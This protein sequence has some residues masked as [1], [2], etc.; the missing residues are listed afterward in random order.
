[1]LSHNCL[2]AL[3]LF[4][5]GKC[6]P[7]FSL[8]FFAVWFLSIAS[9]WQNSRFLRVGL[10]DKFSGA[11][12]CFLLAFCVLVFLVGFADVFVYI[13]ASSPRKRLKKFSSCQVL[14]FWFI[15]LVLGFGLT[16]F[17]L[18]FSFPASSSREKDQV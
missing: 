7:L 4:L 15:L 6:C 10:R 14:F 3:P 2:L 9:F 13:L 18:F 12:F 16:T 11:N 8:V 5:R 1:M 17:F